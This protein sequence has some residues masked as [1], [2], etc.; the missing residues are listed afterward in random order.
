MCKLR[1]TSQTGSQREAVAQI[2]KIC[3][4]LFR[5]ENHRF[6]VAN[7]SGVGGDKPVYEDVLLSLCNALDQRG[8]GPLNCGK[9][10]RAQL[11]G[12]APFA[13]LA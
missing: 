5:G 2:M 13:S 12:G 6:R 4:R 11:C 7:N 10:S 3:S 8:G 1:V 9:G